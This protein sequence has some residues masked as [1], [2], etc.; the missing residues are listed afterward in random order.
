MS[1]QEQSSWIQE[2]QQTPTL[3]CQVFTSYKLCL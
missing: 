3:A 2:I 1:K